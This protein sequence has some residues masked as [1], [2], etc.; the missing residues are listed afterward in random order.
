MTYSI[1]QIE[2]WQ[3]HTGIG[4]DKFPTSNPLTSMSYAYS[5]LVCGM[6]ATGKTHLSMSI[7]KGDR[8]TLFLDTEERAQWMAD[9]VFKLTPDQFRLSKPQNWSMMYKA[10]KFVEGRDEIK[11]VVIDSATDMM[12][13]AE[14]AIRRSYEKKDRPFHQTGWGKITGMVLKELKALKRDGVNII[15]TSQMREEYKKDKATGKFVPRLNMNLQHFADFIVEL[16]GLETDDNPGYRVLKNRWA[17][18][19][20]H[21]TI[22]WSPSKDKLSDLI[23]ELQS[24]DLSH[25]DTYKL[26]YGKNTGWHPP[27]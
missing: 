6:P 11:H 20:R 19:Y 3:A 21:W 13:Y 18:L 1:D 2:D 5:G 16:E 10:F 23:D 7:A 17:P 26:V 24:P 8:D 9:K 12:N 27:L 22:H 25:E 4:I 15:M 14:T